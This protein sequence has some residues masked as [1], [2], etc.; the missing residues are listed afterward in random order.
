MN[1]GQACLGEGVIGS[2]EKAFQ[3]SLRPLTLPLPWSM[4]STRQMRNSGPGQRKEPRDRFPNAS[5]SRP[6][7]SRGAQEKE[8]GPRPFSLES[9]YS[10]R[11]R[12][13]A[14]SVQTG[15]WCSVSHGLVSSPV[16]TPGLGEAA[17]PRGSGAVDVGTVPTISVCPERSVSLDSGGAED[18][19]TSMA[20]AGTSD[21]GNDVAALEISLASHRDS[22]PPAHDLSIGQGFA[23]PIS[24]DRHAASGAAAS[25]RGY[26]RASV[27]EYVVGS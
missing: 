1:L 21:R 22:A 10:S 6:A 26:G 24:R 18:S 16:T 15:S 27:S 19:P 17:E 14:R 3:A 13:L 25:C 12:A 5:I 2:C 9:G 23:I 11:W 7:S 20:H 8:P 4:S